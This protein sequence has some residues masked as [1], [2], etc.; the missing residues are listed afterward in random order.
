MHV[1]VHAFLSI[2]A[3]FA[4]PPLSPPGVILINMHM[5]AYRSTVTYDAVISAAL[6][7]WM[8]SPA[9]GRPSSRWLR[10]DDSSHLNMFCMWFAYCYCC[11]KANF[12]TDSRLGAANVDSLAF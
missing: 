4:P 3:Y 11:R 12:Q 6:A 5:D 1:L 10:P 7:T 8:P 9:A 2:M